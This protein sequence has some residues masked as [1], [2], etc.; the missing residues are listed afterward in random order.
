MLT[1]EQVTALLQEYGY[2]SL[3]EYQKAN[4]LPESGQLDSAT[5]RHLL[6]I[7]YCN[8]PDLFTLDARQP[9][10]KW[11]HNDIT[12]GFKLSFQLPGF[13]K[14]ESITTFTWAFA[15]WSQHANLHFIY[16]PN[17][18]RQTNI[19]IGSGRIDGAGN[20]LAWSELP[21]SPQVNQQ[22][23]QAEPFTF[24]QNPARGR[25]DLGATAAHEIGHALGLPHKPQT[26]RR[27]LPALLDPIYNP[28]IRT[29]QEW[30]IQQIQA[31]YGKPETQPTP[32]K[33][34]PMAPI[35]GFSP[36]KVGL[37]YSLAPGYICMAVPESMIAPKHRPKPSP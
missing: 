5:E 10:A 28:N 2:V 17:P 31:R 30:D 15:Q 29:P 20:T 32:P 14:E 35:P 1:P 26:S 21:P 25:I 12:W 3:V 18:D 23:D 37:D 36:F 27:E 34:P 13:S 11:P 7:R 22:Y 24:S 19:L 9:L 6:Q 8:L 4:F 16:T 33:P